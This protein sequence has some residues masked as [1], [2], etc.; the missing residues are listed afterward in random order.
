MKFLPTLMMTSMMFFGVQNYEPMINQVKGRIVRAQMD[1]FLY[2]L[3]VYSIT[4][5][6]PTN[7]ANDELRLFMSRQIE[8]SGAGGDKDPWGQRYRWVASGVEVTVISDGPDRK[9]DTA[10]DLSRS[11]KLFKTL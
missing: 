9:A 5:T 8:K 3:K 1:H 7:Q 4:D 2:Y 11:V 10:D 6:I